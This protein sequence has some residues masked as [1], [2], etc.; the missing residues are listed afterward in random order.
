M[1]I[2]FQGCEEGTVLSTSSVGSSGI[3]L[4]FKTEG[5]EFCS[6]IQEFCCKPKQVKQPIPSPALPETPK[7]PQEPSKPKCSDMPGFQCLT[8]IT[9]SCYL[10]TKGWEYLDHV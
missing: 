4:T 6:T 7:Q 5:S 2:L 3:G 10:N 1:I 9:V 8:D